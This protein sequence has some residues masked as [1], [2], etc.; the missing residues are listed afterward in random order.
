MCLK[1]RKVARKVLTM[2]AGIF[3]TRAERRVSKII[4]QQAG[5]KLALL[6]KEFQSVAMEVRLK[7]IIQGFLCQA[8]INQG[9]PAN[10]DTEHWND[11]LISMV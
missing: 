7:L 2:G 4:F 5:N 9:F 3:Q 10:K 1:G 8:G 11:L 6:G